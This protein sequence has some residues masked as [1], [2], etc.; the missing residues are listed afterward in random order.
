MA[1][2]A[3]DLESAMPVKKNPVDYSPEASPPE[4]ALA[5][6]TGDGTEFI[7]E[8]SYDIWSLG[9]FLFE[10]ATGKPYFEGQAKE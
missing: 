2:K 8:Y 10:L 1:I 9:M 5:Y 4:F 3:I 6:L 7:L